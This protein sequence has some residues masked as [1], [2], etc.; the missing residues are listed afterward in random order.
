NVG[1]Y[2]WLEGLAHF[3]VDPLHPSNAAITD[4]ALAPRDVT[5]KVSFTAHCAILQPLYPERGNRR[6]LF[7]V[8]NRGRKTVLSNFNSAPPPAAQAAPL[9]PGNVFLMPHGYTVVGCGCQAD[10]PPIPGLMG[11]QAPE[12]LGPDGKPLV[13]KI[14]CQFQADEG[15][16]MFYLADRHHLPH[17]AVD[18]H[19][20]E[21]MLLVRDHPNAPA[22]AIKRDEW[23]FAQIEGEPD[24]HYVCLSSGCEAGK[25]YAM[26]HTRR[27]CISVRLRVSA[28]RGMVSPLK[29][30]CA[31]DGHPCAGMHDYAY[32][33]R[34]S[35][36]GRFLGKMIYVG[37]NEDE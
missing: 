3:A 31:A 24:P 1:P 10:V 37:A 6:L 18:M 14:L 35:Q 29:Y 16:S 5:G 21:A 4:I 15:V 32:V 9:D 27:R 28:V 7:D 36:S 2:Q 19:D 20:P 17:P 22:R 30:S 26:V 11:L 12:A 33:L 23:S 25:I 34:V 8:V 13:G